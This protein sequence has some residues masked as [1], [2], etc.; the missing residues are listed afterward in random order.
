M[1]QPSSASSRSPTEP[2]PPSSPSRPAS[3]TPDSGSGWFRR[4]FPP[5]APP[6]GEPF[7]WL[8]FLHA[9][10]AVVGLFGLQPAEWPFYLTVLALL[11]VLWPFHIELSKDVEIYQPA[12]WTAAAAAYL[13]G[14]GLL[15][16]FWLSTAL[17]F[18]LIVL[19]D[20][21]GLVRAHGITAETVRQVR[22]Q[23][24]PPGVGVDGHLRGF[25][26]IGSHAVRIA[27]VRAAGAVAPGLP[28]VVVVP[29]GEALVNAWLW[30]L[31][32]PGRMS[33]RRSWVRFAAALGFD[34]LV[35]SELLQILMVSFLLLAYERAGATGFVVASV[36]TLVLHAILKR[37]NDTRVESDRRRRELVEM[38]E[39][40]DRRE[41]MAAI[42][43]TASSVFH[44]VARHHGAIGMFAHLLARETSPDAVQTMRAYAERISTSVEEANRVID[45]LL[46]FG[47]DRVLNLY[48]QSLTALI[49]ECLAECRPRAEARRVGLTAHAE[50]DAIVVLDKHK[51]KQAL[52]NLLDNAIE[53]TPPGTRV[54]VSTTLGPASVRLSV[55]DFGPGVAEDIRPRLFTPFCTTKLEGIG[56]GLALAKELV[57]AHGG[58]I[59]WTAADPGTVFTLSLPW[60]P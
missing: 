59:A 4:A 27:V 3:S 16:V 5:A 28:L 33:P 1:S 24:H 18:A 32:V 8:R 60:T 47:Q 29:L 9:P 55:R 15:P 58:S 56:L 11:T 38:R 13:L 17:G 7:A 41:R 10:V 35:V 37:L 53:A 57:E 49:E 50:T 30:A 54:E 26:N 40:L 39:A 36:S 51:V 46:R 6:A 19:L 42:G 48:P 20:G 21:A 14:L 34:M 44:Q 12:S 45:E 2:A 23:P 43:E 22:G 25:V 52:G 31:P